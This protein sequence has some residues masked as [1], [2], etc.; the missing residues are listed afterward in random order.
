MQMQ[1]AFQLRT[2]HPQKRA[3]L[4]APER[5][6]QAGQSPAASAPVTARFRRGSRRRLKVGNATPGATIL[7]EWMDKPPRFPVSNVLNHPTQSISIR[8]RNNRAGTGL[9]PGRTPVF[10][11]RLASNKKPSADG[12][13]KVVPGKNEALRAC[14]IRPVDGARCCGSAW[15]CRGLANQSAHAKPWCGRR[16]PVPCACRPP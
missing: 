16:W 10:P 9:S 4:P 6:A 12:R 14:R 11:L 1:F 8:S 5:V 7:T 15:D 2:M 13:R 3:D